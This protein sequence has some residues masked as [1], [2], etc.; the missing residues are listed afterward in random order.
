MA[1]SH[2]LVGARPISVLSFNMQ[3]K[4]NQR[5]I[6]LVAKHLREDTQRLPDFIL[7]QEVMFNRSER[8]AF[9]SSAAALADQFG[10][11]VAGSPRRSG[12]EGIAIVS[13]YP[14]EHFDFK[15]LDNK[16]LFGFPRVSVMGEFLVPGV[17]RVRVVDVHLTHWSGEHAMR[18]RQLEETLEW[19]AAREAIAPAD[20]LILGGDFNAKPF[21]TE[22]AL[23]NEAPSHM[24]FELMNFNTEDNTKGGKGSWTYRV[25]YIF[26]SA[27]AH[28]LRF[29]GETLLWADGLP[30][31]NGRGTY[32]P[33]DHL[34]V[35]HEY[36]VGR[37]ENR[38]AANT[39]ISLA[40]AAA[41]TAAAMD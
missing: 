39:P 7:C 25:D 13:K 12:R 1:V 19:V 38:I 33:S 27:P 9:S 6:E 24:D 31:A 22:L 18:H 2:E 28:E 23:I 30:K 3:R 26:A 17:G 40:A 35:L 37:R 10:Y 8:A 36:A 21:S 11:H 34:L 29:Q 20:M 41:A 16:S 4:E 15:Q 5:N 14:F 32:W